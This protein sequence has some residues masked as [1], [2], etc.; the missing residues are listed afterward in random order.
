MS[1]PYGDPGPLPQD[2]TVRRR[3]FLARMAALTAAAPAGAGLA[4]LPSDAQGAAPSLPPV[5]LTGPGGAG[6]AP[7][8]LDAAEAL[9]A[10]GSRGYPGWVSRSLPSDLAEVTMAEALLRFRNGGLDPREYTEAFLDRIRRY[11]GVYRAWNSV[12]A[13]A[14]R[15]G[16]ASAAANPGAG[17]LSGIPLA[18]KDNCYTAGVPTTANSHIFRDFVPEHDATVV[19]RLKGAGAIVLGKTQLGPLATTRATTPDGEIT[20]VNA[21][22]PGDPSVSPGGSSSGSATAVAARMAPGSIGTQTGGSITGPSVLQGLTGLKPTMGRASLHGIIPLSYTRDHPGPMVQDALDAALLLQVMAGPD[23]ADPRTQGFP[24]VPDY[25]RA[26]EPVRRGGRAGL[27]WPS[28]IGILPGYLDDPDPAGD[29]R[30]PPAPDDPERRGELMARRT[31]EIRA[32]REMV[33][34]FEALGA[35]VVEVPFPEDWEVLTGGP[36]NN[37]RLPERAEPYLEWLREDVRL[38]GVTLPGWINGLLLSGAE[39]LKGQRAR[40]LL[41][42]RTLLGFFRECD[43]VVQTS[44][45]PFDMLGFP[46]MAFPIGADDTAGP[47]RPLGAILG[48]PAFGEERLLS[49]V[50]GYQSV[51]DWHRRRPAPPAPELLR[52]AGRDGSGVR[53]GRAAP[54][55]IDCADIMELME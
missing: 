4:F 31:A 17:P 16:A 1:D 20:T 5:R 9:R 25:L 26:A 53:V 27:R 47:V 44:P 29:W 33:R 42:E 32:R 50:A 18:I 10:A 51:T 41:L 19:A 35:R 11:D 52:E 22:T 49:L 36:M 34:T 46:L 40:Q 21:W 23:P 55:R 13:E 48:A 8:D 3:D 2:R 45:V 28:T 37:V 39:F 43:A 12:L 7:G 24:P 14:A 38:L 15:R 6:G 54:L 30:G